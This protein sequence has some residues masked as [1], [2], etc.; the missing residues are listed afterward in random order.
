M[1]SAVHFISTLVEPSKLK[2]EPTEFALHYAPYAP[3]T[4][5]LTLPPTA[6]ENADGLIADERALPL[7]LP[8]RTT[9]VVCFARLPYSAAYSAT[10]AAL[11][12]RLLVLYPKPP[13]VG[14]TNEY[15]T[16]P[17]GA[18]LISF[19]AEGALRKATLSTHA[20]YAAL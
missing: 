12:R 3:A 17:Y 16:A 11:H 18:A 2:I 14:C 9:A 4:P 7:P 20:P 1:N 10:L 8:V 5:A 19:A 6:K 13:Q 15:C